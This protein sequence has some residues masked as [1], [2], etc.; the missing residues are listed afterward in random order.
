MCH[1]VKN[2]I[3]GDIFPP[4]QASDFV[5]LIAQLETA[6]KNNDRVQLKKL[7]LQD[8]I[9]ESHLSYF[10]W[11]YERDILKATKT[12][13]DHYCRPLIEYLFFERSDKLLKFLNCLLSSNQPA[14][15]ATVVE[16]IYAQSKLDLTPKMCFSLDVA[17]LDFRLLNLKNYIRQL[18]TQQSKTATSLIESK[19][20]R[21]RAQHD[22]LTGLLGAHPKQS[23]SDEDKLKLFKYKI[24]FFTAVQKGNTSILAIHRTPTYLRV[25]AELIMTLFSIMTLGGLSLIQKNTTGNWS[26]FHGKTHSERYYDELAQGFF[27]NNAG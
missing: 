3:T 26:F 17:A 20:N 25:L 9:Y 27:C 19:L 24:E 16:L 2:H 23:D 14:L 18:E 4:L 10:A 6:I 8:F 1:L 7:L 15:S 11:G 21:I 13:H 5:D 22:L 12:Y